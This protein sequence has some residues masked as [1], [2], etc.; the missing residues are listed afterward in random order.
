MHYHLRR[1]IHDDTGQDLIEYALLVS[2][3]ALAG[4]A[5]YSAISSVMASSYTGGNTAV[6]DLWE[7]PPPPSPTP[8]PS[9]SPAP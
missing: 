5:G 2:F 1:W 7:V 9:P 4:V 8:T 3:I 6:Q